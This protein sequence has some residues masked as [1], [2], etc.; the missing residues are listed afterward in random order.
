L[1]DAAMRCLAHTGWISFR[2]RATVV[3]F[4][5]HLLWQ[6]WRRAS[7]HLAKQFLDYE[8]GIHY[9]QIQ[10]QAGTVGTT[11][12]RVYNPVRQSLEKD[13]QTTF[14]RKWV[15]EL[16][17]LP[18]ALVHEPWKMTAIDELSYNFS[19]G[20]DYPNP[21]IA[22]YQAAYHAANLKLWGMKKDKF[23]AAEN[24]RILRV[25]TKRNRDKDD[26]RSRLH[27]ERQLKK[28]GEMVGIEQL[29]LGL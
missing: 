14:I 5:T 28:K 23:V 10:M 1:I 4:Y 29:L 7:R 12:I 17:K 16:N 21:V 9:P 15:P 27:R 13:P 26:F 25:H 8:P 19:L 20:Y 2:L 18:N 6:D 11:T 22:D 3:S 24:E